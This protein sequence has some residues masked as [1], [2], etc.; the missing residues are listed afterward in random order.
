MTTQSSIQAPLP[1]PCLGEGGDDEITLDTGSSIGGILDGGADTDKLILSGTGTIDHAIEN[2]ETFDSQGDWTLDVDTTFTFNDATISSGTLTLEDATT[3]TVPTVTIEA[4]GTLIGN[5]KIIGDIENYGTLMG[6]STIDGNLTNHGNLNPGNSIGTMTV[7]G[8]YVQNSDAILT[9]DIST[10]NSES[11]LLKITGTATLD[12]TLAINPLGDI[13]SFNRYTVLTAEGGYTGTLQIFDT[14]AYFFD[15]D[16]SDPNQIQVGVTRDF[17]YNA[18]TPNQIATGNYLNQIIGTATPALQDDLVTLGLVPGTTAYQAALDQ[19]HPEFFDAFTGKTFLEN[20]WF[21]ETLGE[22]RN[23]C[24]RNVKGEAPRVKSCGHRFATWSQIDGSSITR[25]GKATHI[26]YDAEVINMA[27]GGLWAPANRR[28]SLQAA[29]GYSYDSLRI[30]NRGTGSSNRATVGVQGRT[31][32]GPF[33]LVGLLSGG[34]KWSESARTIAYST[35]TRSVNQE[36]TAEFNALIGSA[37]ARLEYE[38]FNSMGIQ[39]VTYAG[40]GTDH[41]QTDGFSESYADGLGL[42]IDGFDV[43]RYGVFGGGFIKRGISFLTIRRWLSFFSGDRVSLVASKRR[44]PSLSK[45]FLVPELS[46]TYMSFLDG[47]E[48][49]LSGR[50]LGAQSPGTTL[51]VTGRGPQQ[52]LQIGAWLNTQQS[53][54]LNLAAGIIGSSMDGTETLGGALRLTYRFN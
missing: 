18:V 43:T 30:T 1:A 54:T 23:Q 31:Y 53:T 29:I 49:T 35:G 36:A 22:R 26:S 12:G 9:I 47:Y 20:Y 7:T 37:D 24:W 32:F 25:D 13:P 17:L 21:N 51:S 11:D 19:V 39:A 8:N 42:E 14:G 2:I 34:Y 33:A 48:R 46:M 44:W 10:T 27:L 40:F 5:G 3:M 50:L 15:I 16:F 6:T 28:D 38:A 45:S 52:R 4:A 41:L